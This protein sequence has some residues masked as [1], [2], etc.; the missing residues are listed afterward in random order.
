MTDIKRYDAIDGLRAYAAIGIVAMHFMTNGNFSLPKPALQ[1]IGSMGE[2]VYLFM[3]VSG[4]SMCCGYYNRV[5]SGNLSIVDFYKRRF[6]KVLPFFALLCLIDLAFNPSVG[7]LYEAF[8]NMTLCFGL[9]PNP[10]MS[11]VG[12]G[13]FLGLVF[14]FYLVFPFYCFLLENKKRAWF[15]FAVALIYNYLCSA[16][17]FNDAHVISGFD[18]RA[19]FL[20]C[21]VYFLLGGLIYLYRDLI[22]E[23]C[24][25]KPLAAVLVSVL[26]YIFMAF[27]R[28]TTSA[29]LLICAILLI[30]AIIYGQ[31]KGV[32]NNQFVSLVSSISLEIYL[33][34]M[35]IFR[36][37]E[38]LFR[39]LVSSKTAVSYFVTLCI[40][41]TGA[42]LFAIC[43]HKFFSAFINKKSVQS[44]CDGREGS[45]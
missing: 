3:A 43:Y 23:K 10:T 1:I 36:L 40:V 41:I 5:L 19:N 44:A 27:T 4:F 2:F 26:L 17:F 42:S 32:L 16:Y 35:A 37:V 22:V 45:H 20:F 13:W 24:K 9:L 11:V 31:R 12:V 25:I 18:F 8:A 7:A 15:S 29:L 6:S 38:K 30:A 34:H 28:V 39:P 33:S 21:S 14:V